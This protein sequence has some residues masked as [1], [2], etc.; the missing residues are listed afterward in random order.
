MTAAAP[1]GP[2]CAAPDSL[3]LMAKAATTLFVNG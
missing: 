2:R 1:G 3:E